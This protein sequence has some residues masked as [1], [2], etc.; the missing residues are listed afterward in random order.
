MSETSENGDAR[1]PRGGQHPLIAL[2]QRAEEAR[3][4]REKWE[5]KEVLSCPECGTKVP[6]E[7]IESAVE[8]AEKHDDMRHGEEPTA[9][10]N[11]MVPPDLTEEQKEK[12]QQTVERISEHQDADLPTDEVKHD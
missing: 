6:K 4:R 8:A 1:L 5:G 12:I 2:K 9:K 7:D 3:K 10:V 11:G